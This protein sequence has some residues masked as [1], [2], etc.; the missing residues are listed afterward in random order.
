MLHIHHLTRNDFAAPLGFDGARLG[1]VYDARLELS[2]Q[3]PDAWSAPGWIDTDW[4][5]ARIVEGPRG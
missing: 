3:N 2:V 4:L 1:E 5:P